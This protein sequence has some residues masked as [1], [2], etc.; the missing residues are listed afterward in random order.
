MVYENDGKLD[1]DL[2]KYGCAFLSLAHYNPDITDDVVNDMAHKAHEK[3]I[4]DEDDTIQDW[5]ALCDLFGYNLKYRSGHWPLS[6]AVTEDMYLIGEWYNVNTNFTHFVVMDCKGIGK[7]NVIYDPIKGGSRT[8]AEGK[9]V[10]YRIFD[11][12]EVS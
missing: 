6:T 10:S 12:Q 7:D 5:Q 11:I 3:A 2:A 8:V 4:I 9:M 1:S